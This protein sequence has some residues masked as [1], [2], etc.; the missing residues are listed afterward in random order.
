MFACCGA[1]YKKYINEDRS[2][3]MNS[4]KEIYGQTAELV[5]TPSG[6]KLQ[7]LEEHDEKRPSKENI[8]RIMDGKEPIP[9]LRQYKFCKCACHVHG[10]A[11]MH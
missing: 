11:L 6:Q 10:L 4:L 2:V 7:L 8:E 9:T 1:C 3:D 5:D